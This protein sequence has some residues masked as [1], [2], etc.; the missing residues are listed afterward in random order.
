MARFDTA[1]NIINDAAVEVG[2][3]AVTDP[4]ASTESEFV[5]LIRL[6]KTLGRQLVRQHEW[7]HLTAEHTITVGAL[8][9][10][11]Y[12]LPDDFVS[13]IDQTGWNRT[14]DNPLCPID[15]EQWQYFQ[16]VSHINTISTLIRFWKDK[17]Y[18]DP[19]PPA[20]GTVIAF[21]YRSNFWVQPTGETSP[22]LDAPSASTDTLKFD[23]LLLVTGLKLKWLE[24]KGFDTQAALSDF[25]RALDSALGQMI[26][27]RVLHIDGRGSG[28]RFLSGANIPETGFGS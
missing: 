8:D 15:G 24:S 22:T 6:L 28:Q 21:E 10:G 12:D 7:S 13:M 11:I 17:L 16:A 20:V 19:A 25:N 14:N 9:T 18:T 2:L 1:D 3:A 26:A 27:S 4:F 5:R 23:P